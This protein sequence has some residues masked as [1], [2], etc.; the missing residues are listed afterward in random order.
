MP[1]VQLQVKSTYTLLESTTKIDALI[2]SAK[3]RGY[4]SIAL[5]DKNVIYGLVD[6]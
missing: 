1:F 5:T 3:A 6:F 2:E 4:Q